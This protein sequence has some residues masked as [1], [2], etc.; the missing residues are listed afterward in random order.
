LR[1]LHTFK[2]NFYRDENTPFN[3]MKIL[4]STRCKYYP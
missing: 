2:N 1:E 4:V 3:M